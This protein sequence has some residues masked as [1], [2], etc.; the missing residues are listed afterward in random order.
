MVQHIC[1]R[2]YETINCVEKIARE[3]GDNNV[4]TKVIGY[5]AFDRFPTY[6]MTGT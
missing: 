2:R 4:P 3:Y 1:I 6:R 5:I